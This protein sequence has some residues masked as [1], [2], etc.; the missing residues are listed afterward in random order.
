MEFH[1]NSDSNIETE[2]KVFMRSLENRL[3]IKELLI[4]L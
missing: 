2:E 3:D 4:I 1:L